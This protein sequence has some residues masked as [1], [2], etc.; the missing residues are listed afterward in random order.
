[1]FQS[2]AAKTVEVKTAAVEAREWPVCRGDAQAT[3][4]AHSP[5]PEKL[6]VLWKFNSQQHGFE[7]TVAIVD[8]LVFAGS[9]DGNL[10]VLNLADGKEKWK[11]HTELGFNAAA[12][13]TGGR[14]FAGDADGKFYCFDAA[15]GKPLWGYETQGEIDSGP[16]FYKDKV[17]VGSQDATLY[18]F[19]QATGALTWKYTIGDQ[20]RCSPTVVEGRAFLAGCD[21]KL[22]ILD[23]DKGE[24]I[25]TV[26]IDG[27]TGSGGG[28]SRPWG[29][30]PPGAGAGADVSSSSCGM[31][32]GGM[33]CPSST[34]TVSDQ[35]L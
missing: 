11:F 15:T 33:L 2:D 12:A 30:G 32:I 18:C 13:V 34:F 24:V 19:E 26:E 28:L 21:A 16:N 10:Y 8:G 9:L 3:G 20:V 7:A 23:L 14:V 4:I 5:L 1:M 17:L 6:E 31:R 22:H 25:N 35:G 27:P 29:S